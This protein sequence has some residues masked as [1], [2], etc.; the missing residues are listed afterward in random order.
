MADRFISKPD[1]ALMSERHEYRRERDGEE[2]R[3]EHGEG[4]GVG[5]GLNSF[6]PGL[7]RKAGGTRR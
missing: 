2:A 6:P 5:K 3:E 4:L 7:E 1:F